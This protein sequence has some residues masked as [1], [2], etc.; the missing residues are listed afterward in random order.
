MFGDFGLP[1]VLPI[2]LDEGPETVKQLTDGIQISGERVKFTDDRGG[3]Y[4]VK[5][6]ALRR[7]MYQSLVFD[8]VGTIDVIS[9]A[10]WLKFISGNWDFRSKKGF[11][12]IGNK[13]LTFLVP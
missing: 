13:R 4:L 3:T 1:E 11:A 5:V 9:S 2:F 8:F 12:Y 10:Q 7:D 6:L